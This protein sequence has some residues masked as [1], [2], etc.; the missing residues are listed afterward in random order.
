MEPEGV[1]DGGAPADRLA[2]GEPVAVKLG[3][4][5]AVGSLEEVAEGVGVGSAYVTRT[6]AGPTAPAAPPTTTNTGH[7]ATLRSVTTEQPD[8]SSTP[9]TMTAASSLA[10]AQRKA[11]GDVGQ[12]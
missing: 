9:S 1:A 12:P 7:D 11:A 3:V 5:V 8:S 4:R 2:D 10:P 6:A